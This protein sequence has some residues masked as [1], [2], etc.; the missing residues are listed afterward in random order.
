MDSESDA[1]LIRNYLLEYCAQSALTARESDH[2][3]RAAIETGFLAARREV[4]TTPLVDDLA[5]Y[6]ASLDQA[7]YGVWIGFLTDGTDDPSQFRAVALRVAL[8]EFARIIPKLHHLPTACMGLV[9]ELL[10][11]AAKLHAA[12]HVDPVAVSMDA[13]NTTQIEGVTSDGDVRPQGRTH[14][15]AA[16]FLLRNFENDFAN[17]L[18]ERSAVLFH[19]D[20]ASNTREPVEDAAR[21]NAIAGLLQFASGETWQLVVPYRRR[22]DR[23][24]YFA[25]AFEEV[26]RP[27]P[28]SEPADVLECFMDAFDRQYAAQ[29]EAE[30][31]DSAGRHKLIGQG[32]AGAK[33]AITSQD[34]TQDLGDYLRS[35]RLALDTLAVKFAVEDVD[36]PDHWR[37]AG[38]RTM[39]GDL[40]R[41]TQSF[42]HRLPPAA[43]RDFS[44]PVLA[45]SRDF[46]AL[47]E[48]H[49]PVVRTMNAEGI[50]E[51]IA[52]WMGADGSLAYKVMLPSDLKEA[53]AAVDKGFAS[54]ELKTF[55][56]FQQGQ[57]GPGQAGRPEEVDTII[58]G[59]EHAS[60]KLM[61]ALISCDRDSQ[62]RWSFRG[63]SFEEKN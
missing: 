54:G 25:P 59:L 37:V 24:E 12:G 5:V 11:L 50:L 51:S 53:L 46:V 58:A 35:C 2:Q 20:A 34:V 39:R 45:V 48:S 47:I 36:D 32:M 56:L 6:L 62:N 63:V 60:G 9:E 18:R 28:S 49:I 61:A 52:A 10:P 31:G 13:D 33:T 22:A 30:A 8:D 27:T 41:V 40:D 21:A 57:N 43:R 16:M 23:W 44:S 17:G 1:E 3:A 14:R 38:A 15:N 26:E 19:V 7:L 42:T 4:E 55:G 29:R